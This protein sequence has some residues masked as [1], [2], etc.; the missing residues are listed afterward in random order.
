[1]GLTKGIEAITKMSAKRNFKVSMI[2]IY[3]LNIMY[4]IVVFHL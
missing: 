4:I 2:F 1:M 3:L